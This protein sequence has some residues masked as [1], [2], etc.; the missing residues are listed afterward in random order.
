VK[1]PLR[2]KLI[3]AICLP[4][5]AVYLTVVAL[6]YRRSKQEAAQMENHDR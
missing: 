4:L 2:V 3:L 5:L 6:D 1:F